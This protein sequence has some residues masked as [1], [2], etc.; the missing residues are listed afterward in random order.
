MRLVKK[1]L[2][3]FVTGVLRGIFAAVWHFGCLRLGRFVTVDR[4]S[5]LFILER[6]RAVLGHRVHIGRDVEIQARNGLVEIGLGSG[7]NSYSRVVA[8]ERITIG[9]RCAIGQFVTILDHDHVFNEGRTM[10]GYVT[11]P[12]I[13]GNDVW[14]GDKAIILKGVTIGNGAVIAAGAVVTKN[15]PAGDVVAGIPART[16]K[17]TR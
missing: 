16:L 7:I 1:S 4:G 14:I 15:V 2:A 6:G 5:S 8:F 17:E 10:E 9:E 3:R 13:I 12:I 11:S